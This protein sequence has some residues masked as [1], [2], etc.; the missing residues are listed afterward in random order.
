MYAYIHN[1]DIQYI[2][3]EIPEV[4]GEIIEYDDQI[5]NPIYRDGKIIEYIDEEG[6]KKSRV[7]T[8]LISTQNL[9]SVDLEWFLFSDIE[10]GDIIQERVFSGNPHAESALQAK[11]SAYILSVMEWNPNTEIFE[12]IQA[13]KARIN[14]VRTKFNLN[15]L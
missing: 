7:R 5:A 12:E 9:S 1:G 3:H 13:K 6:E 15:P 8:A 4:E 11:T 2:S 14:E 10:I